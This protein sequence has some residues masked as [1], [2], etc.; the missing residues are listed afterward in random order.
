MKIDI[1]V[2][3]ILTLI[4]ISVLFTSA[5]AEEDA[6]DY[7]LKKG[8]ELR[9]VFLM[10]SYMVN[11][12]TLQIGPEN[13][14]AWLEKNEEAI[15]AYERTLEIVN[16]TLEAYPQDAGAWMN[17][18]AALASL[19]QGGSANESYKEALEIYNKSIEEN[20]ENASAWWLNAETLETMGKSDAALQAYDKV[21]ELNSSNVVGAWIRKSDIH[22]SKNE[23]NES[24]QA[25]D[26]AVELLSNDTGGIA[27]ESGLNITENQFVSMRSGIY[28]RRITSLQRDN[29]T[30]F[31]E[32]GWRDGNITLRINAWWHKG[33]ILRVSFNRYNES[34][35]SFD[36]YMQI[37]SNFANYWRNKILSIQSRLN[38][39]HRAVEALDR[40][41]GAEADIA[42]AMELGGN[43]S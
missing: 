31:S 36:Y 28:D 37:D 38:N 2:T 18:G 7:Y 1:A 6:A 4:A 42:K 23:Q 19:G 11:N 20:S 13:I 39:H 43:S 22:F 27:S 41:A 35:K 8:D 34:S 17:R 9:S 25:F 40:Y 12:T 3:I 29:H 30:G 26:K 16:E 24:M 33:Q 5:L 14:S 15:K 10:E 32:A 21:I